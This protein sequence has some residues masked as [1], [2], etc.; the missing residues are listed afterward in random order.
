MWVRVAPE[1]PRGYPCHALI[2][3]EI[4]Q[5]LNSLEPF[6]H[7]AGFA[8]C[9]YAFPIADAPH[10]NSNLVIAIMATWA[11][12][13]YTYYIE[14][15]GALYAQYPELHC[16]FPFSVFAASTYNLGPHTVCFCHTDFT[17]LAFGWCTVTAL[18]SFN[19]KKGGHLVLWECKL[20]IEFPPRSTILLPSAI[21]SHSNL[22]IAKSESHYSFTQY[23][24]GGLFHWVE[25][26]F[27]TT[28]DY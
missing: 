3:R 7:L 4:V 2:N 19:P 1:R 18:G 9:M 13:L 20:V 25:N 8:T 6:K 26:N 14:R 17:N 16:I 24:A 15:L 21:V 23:T 5:D 28:V 10:L 22:A 27:Q 12:E 11:S